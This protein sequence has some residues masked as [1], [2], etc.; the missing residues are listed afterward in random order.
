MTVQLASDEEVG[1]QLRR[2]F[3]AFPTGVVAVSALREDKTPVGMAVNSFTSISLDPPLVAISLANTSRTWPEFAHTPVI[4]LSILGQ[5]QER[6]SRQ[7]SAREGDRFADIEWQASDEG[8]VYFPG[9]ALWLSCSV[10]AE[11]PGGDHTIVLL[12]VRKVQPFADVE[13]LVFHQSR[14]RIIGE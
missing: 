7:L 1:L 2:A 8:A 10:H 12:Q 3:S 4:G 9:A 11:L 13:P 14:Y 6:V 5:T